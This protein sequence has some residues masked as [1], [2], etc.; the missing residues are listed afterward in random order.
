MTKSDL[1]YSD[2]IEEKFVLDL[3]KV[4]GVAGKS[5]EYLNQYLTA[6]TDKAIK[7]ERG[8]VEN[9]FMELKTSPKELVA[10]LRG[11][12]P[13]S[14]DKIDEFEKQV[15]LKQAPED[16]DLDMLSMLISKHPDAALELLAGVLKGK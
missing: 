7:W 1:Y 10:C 2:A 5:L 14:Q 16:G 3:G 12:V 9:L 13:W 4:N 15:A 11:S 8:K 6:I